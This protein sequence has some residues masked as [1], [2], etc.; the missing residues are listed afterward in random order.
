MIPD[1]LL[2]EV[3]TL[4]ASGLSIEVVEEG[5]LAK[6]TIANFPLPA[7]YSK[8]HSDLLLL[9]PMSYPNG[10]PDMF[11][12]EKEVVL[13]N[14]QVPQK[15]DNIEPHVGK[16]WRRFSWHSGNWNPGQDDLNTYLCF[17]EHG[18][19]KARNK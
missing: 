6:I 11:W 15:A 3:E 12:V 16:Q 8:Q 14:G 17:I 10:K 7:G 19:L 4:R 18:L 2:Q 5:N 9:I 13:A 1:T